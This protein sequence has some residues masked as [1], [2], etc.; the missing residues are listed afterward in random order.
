MELV[1]DGAD[2]DQHTLDGFPLLWSELAAG[3]LGLL[4]EFAKCGDGLCLGHGASRAVD[5]NRTSAGFPAFGEYAGPFAKTSGLQ[6]R[7]HQG[8]LMFGGVDLF[9]SVLFFA[10]FFRTPSG[11]PRPQLS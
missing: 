3:R 10:P 5:S 1:F 4:V 6:K 7:M 8:D 9:L 11:M 2:I